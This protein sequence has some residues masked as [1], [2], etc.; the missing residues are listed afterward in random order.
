MYLY[1]SGNVHNRINCMCQET[2]TM[3][4]FNS[5]GNVQNECIC[6]R[7]ETCTTGIVFVR[8]RAQWMY[9]T[10][11]ETCKMNES[12]N[13]HNRYCIRQETCTMDVFNSVGNV[14]NEC[15]CM[16]QETCTMNVYVFVRKRAQWMYSTVLETCKMN[17][18]VRVRKRAQQVLYS[19]GNVHN[20][21][22]HM[23]QESC[24]LYVYVCQ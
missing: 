12:G 20:R 9:S 4:V 22:I 2:C 23:S 19:S 17:V 1:A 5:V 21:R 24:K 16:N 10:V 6:M 3:D 8:K 15:I 14:Q 18:F 11:L 7:Q 13:V